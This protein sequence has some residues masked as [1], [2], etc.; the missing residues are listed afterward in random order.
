MKA[1]AAKIEEH[2]FQAETKKTARF[3]DQFSLHQ[4]GD[5]PAR[6][7]LQSLG[8][9]GHVFGAFRSVT[10]EALTKTCGARSTLNWVGFLQRDDGWSPSVFDRVYAIVD[11]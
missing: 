9:E 4:Q 1:E 5:F 11:S 8:R 10:G 3:D 7:D 6:V 2:R